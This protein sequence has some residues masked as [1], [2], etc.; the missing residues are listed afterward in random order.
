MATL[1]GRTNAKH[2]RVFVDQADG[3]LVEIT[4]Y[5]NSVGTVGLTH[6][7]TDVTAFSDG[8]KNVTIGQPSAPISL[9]GPFDTTVHTLWTGLVN[10]KLTSG[11]GLSFDVRIGIR[12]T[13]DE[14]DEPQFGI[15]GSSTI[16]YQLVTYNLSSALVWTATL[17]PFGATAP[18]W[19][20]A[21]EE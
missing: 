18:A 7:S 2:I 14:T 16:G 3:T 11:D 20:V 21:V 13:A 8:A 17:E 5:T 6:E 10:G 15:T 4:A 1:T 9:S 19:G 12:A